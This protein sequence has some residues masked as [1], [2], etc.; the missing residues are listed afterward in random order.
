MGS[1]FSLALPALILGWVSD[2]RNWLFATGFFESKKVNSKIVSI[3]NLTA[4]GSGKTPFTCWVAKALVARKS[5]V[6]VLSRGYGRTSK[7]FYRVPTK[8]GDPQFFGDEPTWLASKLENISVYVGEN[9]VKAC[10]KIIALESPDVIVL[11]DGFQHRWIYRDLD[12]LLLD[13][14]EDPKSYKMFPL[15]RAREKFRNLQRSSLAILTKVNLSVQEKKVWLTNQLEKLQKPFA[16][17]VLRVK[18]IY[19]LDE[20][21]VEKPVSGKC[22]L[23]SGIAN[24]GA[25]EKLIEQWK[26]ENLE[27]LGH[28]RFKDHHKYSAG[29]IK[30]IES[31]AIQFGAQTVLTTEKDATKL[32]VLLNGTSLNHSLNCYLVSTEQEI[33]S[34]ASQIYEKFEQLG[35]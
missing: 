27:I 33:I 4:G 23:V 29:D 28:V 25:F 22:L 30:E 10:E 11:D 5:R 31:R 21:R 1:K 2:L 17:S 9:R 12:F 34:G 16:E 35:L 14:T 13:A 32:K 24:P 8:G 26:G 7:G 18:G 20:S 15:G 3:G 6:A 19:G